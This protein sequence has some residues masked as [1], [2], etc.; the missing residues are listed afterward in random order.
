MSVLTEVGSAAPETASLAAGAGAPRGRSRARRRGRRTSFGMFLCI[1]PFMVLIF[2]FSYFPLYGWIYSLYDYRPALGLAGSEFVG[3]Q[4]FE[5]MFNSPA[6]IAQIGQVLT[7]T[8]AMSFLGIATSVLPVAFAIFLNEIKAPWFRNSVQTLTT[9]PNFISWV[10]VYMIAFSL[11]SSTGLVNDVLVD[12]GLITAPMKFLDSGG[13]GVWITM[14]LWSLW[15][16]LGWG[17]IIYLAA[18]AGIDPSLYESAKLD[19]AGRFQTMWHI[20]VPQ[21]MP[22]YIVL[23]MLSIANLLNNGME[24]Y[25]VFQ[26]AFNKEH[27][28]VLDLYV[29]NIGLTGNNLSMATAVG[30]LKSLISVV[31]LFT[32]NAIAKRTRGSS[33]I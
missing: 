12:S 15:K 7:N 14:T 5:L 31:L 10:L 2:L 13:E 16:G 1:V 23:L 27:I 26:N 9:M 32:V 19:G 21:L 24:Q 6:Q 8:L 29:Y 18:I 33:I 30:M 3:L 25:F 4:W 22:T 11:F 28:E 17:A 20:T